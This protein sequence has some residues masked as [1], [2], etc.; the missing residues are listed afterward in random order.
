MMFRL[1]TNILGGGLIDRVLDVVDRKVDSETERQKVKATVV[2]TWLQN[3]VSLPWWLD[4]LFIFPLACWWA[5]NSFYN[6]FWCQD[7]IF[8]QSWTIA[9]YPEPLN[10]WAGWIILSRFGGPWV[11]NSIGRIVGR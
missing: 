6:I 5:A 9:G 3:R 2:N 8:A 1:L 11:L 7:C 4:G 10:A